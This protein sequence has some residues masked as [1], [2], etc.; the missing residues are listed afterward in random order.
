MI[1]GASSGL[2]AEFARQLAPRCQTL[3]LVARRTEPM[4]ALAS[5]LRLEHPD[6]SVGV[7]KADLTQSADRA[8][9]LKQLAS[10]GLHPD[11]LVNN[12]GMGDYGEFVK[13]DWSKTEAMIRLNV[14]ALTALTHALVPPMIEGGG[15][16]VIQVSSLAS[17][18]PI[19]D[20]AVY[21]ATKAYV[22]SFSEALRLELREQGIR[23]TALCPGPVHTNFGEV[24]RRQQTGDESP[25]REAFYVDAKQVV[26]EALSGLACN[27]P[28]V[29]PGWKVAAAAAVIGVLPLVLIRLAMGT[30]PRR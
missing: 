14:E 5:E 30:R 25:F 1:T 6:L 24:A 12:A 4:E 16:S 21:A 3:V 29:F 10:A 8:E 11:L 20:F 13:S 22:T 2:G 28:R 15:G 18:L 17:I 23:V 26:K 7:L 9:L 27:A 19:P